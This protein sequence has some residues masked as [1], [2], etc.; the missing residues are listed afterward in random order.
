M[1]LGIVIGCALALHL[2]AARDARADSD[3]ARRHFEAGK[4][5]RDDGDCA[6][7][8]SEFSESLAAE[9][10]IGA[11]YNLGYC[12][13]QL[14]H[15]QEAYDAYV[16]ARQL[17]SA[18]KDDRLREISG[19]LAGLLE[20]PHIRLVL[21]QPLPPGTEIRVDDQLV[22][23]GVYAAET[24][25]FTSGAKTHA[26]SVTAPGYEE[27]RESV[28]T[29]QV[30]PIELRRAVL[31]ETAPVGPP[32]KAESGGGWS[33][34]HWTGIGTSTAGIGVFT[35]GTVM[36]VSYLLKASNLH[37]RY[38]SAAACAKLPGSVSRCADTA[39]E[40]ERKRR[41]DQYN[42][43]EDKASDQAPVMLA[44]TIGGALLIGGGLV[45]FLTAP[46]STA[47]ESPTRGFHIAPIV[48]ATTRGV[49]LGGTF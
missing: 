21:P 3:S 23:S 27:R 26:V 11:Y 7:A 42:A 32:P 43:N 13:E 40:D 18:K 16:N 47:T 34:Q 44:T 31:K 30:K 14:S 39:R 46:K 19:A 6:R 22:P 17:A 37:D 12:H 10:S 35:V 49:A 48:G 2:V 38:D 5:L 33:W 25:V 36:F 45:L 28:D 8:I 4:K 15:R 41:M 24:V 20:T 29:K 1:R 9:K